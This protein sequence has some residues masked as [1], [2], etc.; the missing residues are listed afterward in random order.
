[1]N[2][3]IIDEINNGL[4]ETI[5]LYEYNEDIDAFSEIDRLRIKIYRENDIVRYWTW[6]FLDDNDEQVMEYDDPLRVIKEIDPDIV[7]FWR[8]HPDGRIV[9]P[10]V[11]RLYKYDERLPQ[12]LFDAFFQQDD[13][14]VKKRP[15]KNNRKSPKK[16]VAK[17][18]RKSPKKRP[19]KNNR[20]SPKKRV[21]K[22]NKKSPKKR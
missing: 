7:E 1:M 18:N 17:N 12:I 16:R 13:N 11:V 21:A 3:D 9:Q 20:K 10:A 8:Q 19:A 6:F 22:S 14:G 2:I 15:V 5:V 4:V